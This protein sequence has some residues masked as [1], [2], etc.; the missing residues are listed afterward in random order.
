MILFLTA[1]RPK[2]QLTYAVAGTPMNDVNC[3]K[4]MTD[5]DLLNARIG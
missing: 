2:S 5:K 4:Q 1:I 3:L